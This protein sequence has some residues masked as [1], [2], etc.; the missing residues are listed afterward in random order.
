MH[1][2]L[3]AFFISLAAF[4][5]LVVLLFLVLF[6][7][8]ERKITNP[9]PLATSTVT[10]SASV[11]A[12]VPQATTAAPK[13]ADTATTTKKIVVQPKK[14]PALPPPPEKPATEIER[15]KNA[16]DTPPESFETVNV[17][18]RAALV[19]I[20]CM[21]SRGTLNP[22]SGSG[23]IIDSRGVILTNAHVAQ[24][25]LL[26]QSRDVDITCMV[27]TGSPATPLWKA[28]VL[29]IPPAW[30]NEHVQEIN[31]SNAMGTG[32][33]DYA[34]LS[35]IRNIDGSPVTTPLP[36]LQPDVRNGIGFENDQVL[37]A[38][39]PAEFVG[40]IT[41]QNNLYPVSSITS[42][43]QLLTFGSGSVDAFSIGGVIE[44]QGGSSGGAVVNAWRRLLGIIS[45]TSAG[46]TTAERD[47]RAVSLG[48]IDSDLKIQ[49][50]KNLAEYLATDP[51][52][53]AANF[54]Q[55]IAPSL[56]KKYLE[57]LTRH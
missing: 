15:V 24:F 45:I 38:A 2:R 17:A 32:E 28:D 40:G 12:T 4:G 30:V 49:T 35:I 34:L 48:Y 27:R 7:A 44:A 57:V 37:A 3:Q 5:F 9:P 31:Q 55:D 22:I 21:P 51:L 6:T 41:A 11:A 19:N 43:K 47:L 56:L 18:T 46:A 39:Y 25:V 14:Q 33:H 8:P 1:P 29:Y 16:Y 23:V 53:G 50:G 13:P 36:Y 42:I 26:S 20:L 54:A 10:Q 52:T